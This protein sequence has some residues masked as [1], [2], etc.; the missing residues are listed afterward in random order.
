MIASLVGTGI[1]IGIVFS[2][3]NKLNLEIVYGGA[4]AFLISAYLAFDTI[5]L[6]KEERKIR[7][8]TTEYIYTTI[9]L[10]VGLI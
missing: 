7:F 2:M 8:K 1:A 3:E 10:F 4:G 5:Q 9:Q 6:M